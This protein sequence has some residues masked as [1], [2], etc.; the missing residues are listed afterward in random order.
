MLY[1]EIF[2]KYI[3]FPTVSLFVYPA[4][5]VVMAPPSGQW[6]N[7]WNPSRW[8]NTEKPLPLLE[9][10]RWNRCHA[11]KL[12]KHAYLTC[13]NESQNE[14]ITRGYNLL[15]F[16]YPHLTRSLFSFS[17]RDIRNIGVRLPGH[18]KRIAYSI[19]G[20]QDPTVTLDLFAVW[21]ILLSEAALF[22]TGL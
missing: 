16:I 4:L 20:L 14:P 1:I 21:K 17:K 15:K 13:I 22:W 9:L 19:L 2:N 18:Q 12:S 7:G 3:F 5:V 11:W 10:K 6:M 8:P